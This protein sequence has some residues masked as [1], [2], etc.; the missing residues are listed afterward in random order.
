MLLCMFQ[1]LFCGAIG[2]K[3]PQEKASPIQCTLILSE[4]KAKGGESPKAEVVLKNVGKEQIAILHN[5]HVFEHLDIKVRNA[6]GA[7]ISDGPYGAIFSPSSPRPMRVLDL[8]PGQ[9]CRASVNVFA[10]T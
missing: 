2:D 7:L 8:A 1:L 9:T 6:G 3:G 4:N 10:T 5:T